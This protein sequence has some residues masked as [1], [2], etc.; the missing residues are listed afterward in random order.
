MLAVIDQF[1]ADG[2]LGKILEIR[3]RGK[4]DRRGGGEDLWVLGSHVLNLIHYFGG[5]PLTCSARMFQDGQPVVG[6]HVKDGNEGLGPLAGN[7]LHALRNGARHD[8]LL[9]FHRQRRHAKPRLRPAPR[10][11]QRHPRHSQDRQ[12]FA[13]WV[14]GNPL[15]QR[16]NPPWTPFTTAG[17][18]KEEPNLQAVQ[19]VHS[20]V[21]P[22]R[23]LVHAVH[24][25]RQPLCN[26]DEGGMTVE[27]ICAVFESHCQGGR[28]VPIPLKERGN[29]LAKL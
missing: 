23:D 6:T 20:H 5:K 11:Q 13:Y 25:N 1:I 29:A 26:L 17:T 22:A 27:M 3:G 16:A 21:T 9:R 19:D 18:G 14:P 10:R 7:A 4:G 15:A 24:D 2:H 12:P 28:A 8:R